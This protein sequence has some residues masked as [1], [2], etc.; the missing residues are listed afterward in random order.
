MTNLTE[1]NLNSNALVKDEVLS[2]LF[3][4][5]TL[6][7]NGNRTITDAGIRNLTN[8]VTLTCSDSNISLDCISRLPSSKYYPI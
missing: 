7:M 2:R 4:L 3:S 6:N 1:L 5:T 8:L